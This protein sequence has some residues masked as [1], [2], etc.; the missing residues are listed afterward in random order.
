MAVQAK[1]QDTVFPPPLVQGNHSFSSVTEA[2]C[3]IVESRPNI[4]WLGSFLL[5][6][7]VM[8][9]A[10]AWSIFYYR[11]IEGRKRTVAWLV[12]AVITL[13]GCGMLGTAA[14]D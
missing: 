4:I 6:S 10:S 8:L 2:V 1:Q 3:S 11:E 13:C 12:A 7:S 14:N 5:A 9:I